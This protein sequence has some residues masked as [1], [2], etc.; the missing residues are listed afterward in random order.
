MYF[1]VLKYLRNFVL[2]YLRNSTF[3]LKY[4][5]SGPPPLTPGGV[6]YGDP[7]ITLFLQNLSPM[8]GPEVS[9]HIWLLFSFQMWTG[10]EICPNQ[11]AR[12]R[13]NADC[14]LVRVGSELSITTSFPASKCGPLAKESNG[15]RKSSLQLVTA[16]LWNNFD[17]GG[18]DL[19]TFLSR[20][21]S[22]TPA[23]FVGGPISMANLGFLKM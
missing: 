13:S 23:H 7:K 8:F 14:W 19:N 3:L 18:A 4:L 10:F 5:R 22:G 12:R 6:R 16:M 9:C 15:V 2:K 1:F 21:L 17:L 20:H 11:A